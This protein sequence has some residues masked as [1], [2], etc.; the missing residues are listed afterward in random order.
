MK[1]ESKDLLVE[2][3]KNKRELEEV[4]KAYKKAESDSERF[5]ADITKFGKR[6]GASE[7]EITEVI[8]L[9][10]S[11]RQW[12]ENLLKRIVVADQHMAFLEK[13]LSQLSGK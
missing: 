4:K 2:I 13:E 9:L 3:A 7:E 5:L 12:E 11:Q 8:E 6:A 10:E 1:L